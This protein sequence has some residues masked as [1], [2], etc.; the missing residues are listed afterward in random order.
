LKE[1]LRQSREVRIALNL[2]WLPL[3][4]QQLV[5]QLFSK[6]HY[7]RSAAPELSDA[8]VARLLRPADA[9]LTVADVA[10]LDEAAELLG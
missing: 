9:P 1:D 2:L 3:T 8:E 7:L 5:G 10:L 6:E 4:P